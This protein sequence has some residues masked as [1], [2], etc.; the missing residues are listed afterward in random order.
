VRALKE[1]MMIQNLVDMRKKCRLCMECD[2]AALVNGAE[3]AFD[4]NVVS[5][6][7][8]WLG[9]PQPRLLLVAQDFSDV[10]YFQRYQGASN[11]DSATNQK[12]SHL[13]SVAGLAPKPGP[14][15]DNETRV[16]LTNSILCL[17]Q[18]PM[19]RAISAKW[20]RNCATKQLRP[21]IEQLQPTIVVGM[22]SHGWRAVR[23]AFDLKDA[24]KK[25]S[26]VAGQS[27]KL[28]ESFVFA[29]G[30]CAPQGLANRP[31]TVQEE[32]WRRIG[33]VLGNALAT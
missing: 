1:L 27:W 30:H 11:R 15:P 19:N 8:Q 16:F 4:P 26:E 31:I 5:Y 13:L 2:S 10:D 3:F 24:P 28:G 29:V 14:E 25:L 6:W 33:L 18:P 23:S 32:D 12:L 17:K 20:V 21:L 22:G 9:H 7:S